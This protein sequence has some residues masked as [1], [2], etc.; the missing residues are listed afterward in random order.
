MSK[1]KSSPS[2]TK[3]T[4][5]KNK[6]V[7]TIEDEYKNLSTLEH[8]LIR[9]DTYIGQIRK[10]EDV[11]WVFNDET[12]RMEERKL[13]FSPGAIKVFDEIIVNARDQSVK[14]PSEVTQIN[15]EIDR[16][17]GMISVE[18][19]G[20]GIP[21]VV[22]KEHKMWLPQ[23]IF[24][25]F[26]S[27]SNFNDDTQNRTCG[28]KNG[29]G[30]KATNGLSSFF[31]VE[32]RDSTTE[33]KYVQVWKNNMSELSEPK[34]TTHKSKTKTGTK[35]SFILDWKRFE[36]EGM[37]D[38]F[39]QL[40]RRRVYDIA[41][42]TNS[43]VTVKLNGERMPY[44]D[45]DKYVNLFIG[46]ASETP[47]VSAVLKNELVGGLNIEWNVTACISTKGFKTISFVNG[48]YTKDGGKHVDFITSRLYKP[49]K[50]MLSERT[51]KGNDVQSD[52]IK[53]QL[54]LFINAVVVNPEF[55]SQSKTKLTSK[56][57]DFQFE[58]A[59]LPTD[60]IKNLV[61][62][63]KLGTIAL[64]YEKFRSD[65]DISSKTDGSKTSTLRGVDK[66]ED[67][68]YAGTK[69]SGECTVMYT[70]GDSAKTLAVSGF[71][72]VGR[73]YWGV[74]PLRGK[75]VNVKAGNFRKNK[76]FIAFK[77]IMGLEEGVKYTDTKRLR[78]GRIMFMTDQDLDGAH[79][80]GLLMNAIATLWPELL[81]IPGF[82]CCFRTPIVK[83]CKGKG[84]KLEIKTWFTQQEFERWRKTEST[85]GWE[86]KYLKGLGSSEP[87][88]AKRY[89]MEKDKC[90]IEYYT[91]DLKKTLKYFDKA[92]HKDFANQRKTWLTDDYDREDILD[93]E[94][95]R[96]NFDDFINKSL[97][98][99]FKYDLER[100]VSS[101]CD[102]F[103]V[104]QRKV[105]YGSRK[106]KLKK[107]VKVFQLTGA[108]AEIADYHHGETSLQGTIIG[109]A[110]N[111]TGSNNINVLEPE[112]QFGSRV[113]NGDDASAARYI[114]TKL[115][116]VVD[117]IFNPLD[118]PLLE[119]REDDDGKD[120]QPTFY[121]PIIPMVLVNGCEGIGTGFSTNVPAYNPKDII[122][123]IRNLLEGNKIED[124]I[125]WY[126]DFKGNIEVLY[127]NDDLNSSDVSS[128]N[129]SVKYKTTG[130]YERI[131]DTQ[132]RIT[133]LPVGTNKCKSFTAYKDFIETLVVGKQKSVDEDNDGED[134]E[135]KKKKRK[136]AVK[137][138]IKCPAEVNGSDD[139]CDFTI[140]FDSKDVLSKFISEGTLESKMKLSQA[141]TTSNM[142]L[143]NEKDIIEKYDTVG[144]I[145][146]SF[147]TVRLDYY[148]KRKAYQLKE[149]K[150]EIR[151]F[152]LQM[153]FLNLIM[154][155]KLIVFKVPRETIIQNLKPL[156]PELEKD[157]TST[158]LRMGIHRFT[159]QEIE[160]LEEEISL[161]RIEYNDMESKDVKDMWKDELN[162]LE[163]K[164]E[165][166]NRLSLEEKLASQELTKKTE[167]P[168]K[169]TRVTKK[170]KTKVL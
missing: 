92:F 69:R 33:K 67:A 110:Q 95:K 106:K 146:R 113:E 151:K 138:F 165:E 49:V 46:K 3:K 101:M 1:R 107:S 4:I 19:N 104:S 40:I 84:S 26:N 57:T 45:F 167:K 83:A 7:M 144:D 87:K 158:L 82:I 96:I 47:R 6:T 75:F 150:K 122:S 41:A 127:G 169:R 140:T 89:F 34:I 108:I 160:K 74:M 103:K 30:G 18:N 73:D 48:L 112:G 114:F 123:N 85:A 9:P 105:L 52:H 12:E 147:Y 14:F 145:L 59:K 121:V 5:K 115:S 51:K 60:F 90:I 130:V 126:R 143:F 44:R 61:G 117:N 32:T 116:D 118:D 102:G 154:D 166:C 88:D 152:E 163:V 8:L 111:Y 155:K 119:L 80:Q 93:N 156:M 168:K 64:S 135:K 54:F 109:M 125:P 99:F 120:I 63:C 50:D 53:Q 132:I 137:E 78:Y 129:T 27:G 81:L 55:N 153:K 23:M 72:V 35:I 86:T 65:M 76:E 100:S 148:H 162:E 157:E 2:S 97:V 159:H 42:C 66:L 28:G 58:C 56:I 170:Q 77:K 20:P 139:Y 91:D 24:G 17:T 131:S 25:E 136:V 21:V 16:E 13:S 70:E 68:K 141:I 164:I 11:E 10:T 79:I 124:M 31:Q 62:K 22:H 15:V 39:Y 161:K 36:M 43:T 71:S 149:I 29:V 128:S 38:D 37:D 134:G 94:L 98:H 142:Y 133:E